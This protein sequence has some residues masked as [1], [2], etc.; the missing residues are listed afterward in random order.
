MGS[1]FK[2]NFFLFVFFGFCFSLHLY[3]NN[4]EASF[5]YDKSIPYR[6]IKS[7]AYSEDQTFI[8]LDDGS[9]WETKDF[10]SCAKASFWAVNDLIFISPWNSI[11]FN[12]K[13]S[14]FNN[15]LLDYSYVNLFSPPSPHLPTHLSIYALSHEKKTITLETP[16]G[17]MMSFDLFENPIQEWSEKESII[18]GLSKNKEPIDDIEFPYIIINGNKKT[19]VKAK[20]TTPKKRSH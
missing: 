14:F 3:T 15:R 4:Q 13:Y 5:F 20:H 11:F 7:V 10:P 2:I 9:I 18:I 19:F 17:E 16:S 8:T 6:A 12:E 1:V